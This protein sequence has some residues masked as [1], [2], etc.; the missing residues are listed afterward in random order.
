MK[1]RKMVI[2]ENQI[3]NLV[4]EELKKS[5]VL[6]IVKHDKDFEKKVKEIIADALSEFFR[7]LWQHN[8]IFKSMT[9]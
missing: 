8:G 5:D 1:M 6:D 4:T 2:N 9:R 7:V 3:V